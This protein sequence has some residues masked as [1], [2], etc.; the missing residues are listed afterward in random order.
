MN[1]CWYQLLPSD[2]GK[3]TVP[4]KTYFSSI[5]GQE[6]TM[7]WLK[8]VLEVEMKSFQK[9][10]ANSGHTSASIANCFKWG[11][12]DLKIHKETFVVY[13]RSENC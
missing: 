2:I 11:A 1:C 8:P 4:K 12:T 3:V 6:L 5:C 7:G 13:D 9:A 10:L